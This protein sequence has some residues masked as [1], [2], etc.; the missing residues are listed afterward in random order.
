MIKTEEE[1]LQVK[2]RRRADIPMSGCVSRKV[3]WSLVSHL[4]GRLPHL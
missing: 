4:I 2:D 1:D 3:D